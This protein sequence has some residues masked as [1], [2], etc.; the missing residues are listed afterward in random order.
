VK[1][2][3]FTFVELLIG[4]GIVTL[5]AG[6]VIITMSR[7]AA[8]VH[9]GSFNALAANQASWIV[10]VMRNDIARSSLEKIRFVADAD[11]IW[12]GSGEFSARIDAGKTVSYSVETRGAGKVFCRE[13]SGGR[14]QN[15][16]SE[17]LDDISVKLEDGCF[18][19]KMLLRDP[20]KKAADYSWSAR[21]FVPAA[22]GAERFWKPLARIAE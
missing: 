15:L 13:E 18:F 21:I 22:I 7:G 12:R 20:G 9:R 17:Y 2:R 3:A 16:A 5:I 1:K 11:G 14:R 8:N 10:A 19:I 6:G 4:V